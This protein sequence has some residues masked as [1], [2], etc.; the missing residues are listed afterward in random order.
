MICASQFYFSSSK[1]SE[2]FSSGLT[3]HSISYSKHFGSIAFGLLLHNYIFLLRIIF[4][5]FI[6]YLIR[7]N[8]NL[9]VQFIGCLLKWIFATIY[10]LIE[11]NILIVMLI[12]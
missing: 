2:G 8:G 5:I 7:E 1:N 11:K 12:Q 4:D 9:I 10:E 6:K 3:G